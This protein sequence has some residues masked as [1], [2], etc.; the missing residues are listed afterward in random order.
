M[1]ER[2]EAERQTYL[3]VLRDPEPRS[4]HALPPLPAQWRL[5]GVS[6]QAGHV[7]VAVA[8][9]QC[10]QLRALF[11]LSCSLQKSGQMAWSSQNQRVCVGHGGTGVGDVCPSVGLESFWTGGS[12]AQTCKRSQ[13]L[14]RAAQPVERQP[15]PCPCPEVLVPLSDLTFL[16][17]PGG[18]AEQV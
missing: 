11:E 8:D 2:Q 17:T 15:E 18:G 6:G 13:A 10:G 14:G 3:R 9:Q 16:V 1:G 5:S 4:F 12:C 7:L